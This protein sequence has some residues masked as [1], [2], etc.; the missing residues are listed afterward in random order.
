M[1][2]FLAPRARTQRQMNA[3]YKRDAD[4]Y[5]AFRLQVYTYATLTVAMLTMAVLTMTTPTVAMLT[6]AMLIMAMLTMAMLTM[7]TLTVA[8]HVT[9]FRGCSS[10]TRW[11]WSL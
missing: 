10:S 5:V 6:M 2:R 7:A 1:R 9:S 8:I 11:W 4:I 3:L